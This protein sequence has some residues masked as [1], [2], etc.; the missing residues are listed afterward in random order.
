M[1]KPK[2]P[3]TL[4]TA[5]A[6]LVG[7]TFVWGLAAGEYR[8]FP[9]QHLRALKNIVDGDDGSRDPSVYVGSPDAVTVGMGDRDWGTKG[10]V[11]MVGDS[12][13]AGGRWDEMFPDL[14][15]VNR[16]VGGDT[17]KGVKERLPAIHAV[18]ARKVF[19]LIGTNDVLFD[20]PEE[21][22]IQH[23]SDVVEAL[24]KNGSSTYIQS[25]L[26]CGDMDQCT[27]ARRRT[28]RTLNDKLE[29]LSDSTS[30]T[31]IDL[32]AHLANEDGLRREFTWDGLHLNGAGYREWRRILSPH[33]VVRDTDHT[34]AE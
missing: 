29:E 10:E 6:I 28:I 31:F 7:A 24:G 14:E 3:M 30:A 23:Y 33:M 5:V 13:T 21:V 18:E 9:Y 8:I 4:V 11:V 17:V 27:P 25:I 16:G 19:L 22:I 1:N 2:I 12:I 20:N 34:D 26:Q 32:N 15:I